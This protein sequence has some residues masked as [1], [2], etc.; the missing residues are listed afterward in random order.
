MQGQAR[1]EKVWQHLDPS[2]QLNYTA[3]T[4]DQWAKWTRNDAV[5]ILLETESAFDE[6][7]HNFS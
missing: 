7:F 4:E 3:A 6:C 1:K 5:S 2:R